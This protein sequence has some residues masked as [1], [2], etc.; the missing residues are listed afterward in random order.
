MPQVRVL[1]SGPMIMSFGRLAQM[2]RALHT[3]L[4]VKRSSIRVRHLPYDMIS[5][6]MPGHNAPH[7]LFFIFHSIH[8]IT[9][10]KMSH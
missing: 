7:F 8:I 1:S 4:D 6:L 2:V 9:L 5:I 3:S 10:N